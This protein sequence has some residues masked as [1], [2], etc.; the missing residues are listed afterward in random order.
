MP[1]CY[2]NRVIRCGRPDSPH[3]DILL[4]YCWEPVVGAFDRVGRST[5]RDRLGHG[6]DLG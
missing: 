2:G 1:E 5:G 4:Q 6:R 3:V